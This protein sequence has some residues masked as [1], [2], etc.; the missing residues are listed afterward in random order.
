MNVSATEGRVTM[1]QSTFSL[2]ALQPESTVMPASTGRGR[3]AGPN[4]FV[5][6]LWKSYQDKTAYAVKLPDVEAARMVNSKIRNAA[7]VLTKEK[8][9]PVGAR[10][11][12]TATGAKDAKSA[13]LRLMSVPVL[14]KD[15]KPKLA[16]DRDKDGKLLFNED[17]S[18][19]MY[20]E[21][22]MDII[23]VS[24]DKPYRGPVTVSYLGQPAKQRKQ[25]ATENADDVAADEA[26]E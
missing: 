12:F 20:V 25:A 4:P 21:T 26:G 10:V 18:P 8:A 3:S 5:E 15:G 2:E 6:W 1:T 14:D 22:V 7:A 11:V 24:T 9:K 16:Q 19:S 17:G 13:A 23:R